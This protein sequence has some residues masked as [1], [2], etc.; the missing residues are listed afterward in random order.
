MNTI[1]S[2]F[3]IRV[4]EPSDC[5]S[6]VDLI[7]E[8]AVFEKELPSRVKITKETLLRDGFG[9]KKWF[10]CLLAEIQDDDGKKMTIGY[11]LYFP[12]YSTWNGRTIKVEDLYIKQQYRGKGYGTALLKEVARLALADGC[13]RVHWCV[14]DWNEPAIKYY[15]SIGAEYQ[16][17]WR[18][19]TLHHENMLEFVQRAAISQGK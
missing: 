3:N 5:Q 7:I 2:D 15:K 18:V 14:L 8:L 6:I 11:A 17:E 19:C 13:S 10:N 9:E 12:T 16:P 1:T 4:A